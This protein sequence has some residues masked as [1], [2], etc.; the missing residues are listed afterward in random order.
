[1]EWKG[2]QAPVYHWP[3]LTTLNFLSSKRGYELVVELRRVYPRTMP[4]SLFEALT[5]AT[6]SLERWR[7]AL[8]IAR[9]GLFPDIRLLSKE[10]GIHETW[11]QSILDT[12]GLPEIVAVSELAGRAEFCRKACQN[13][14]DPDRCFVECMQEG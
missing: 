10:T 5:R 4:E 6:E 12:M 3:S 13:A 11:V 7:V 1:M 9:H 14:P 8:S 2:W